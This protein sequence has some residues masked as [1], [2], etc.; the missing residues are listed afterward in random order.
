MLFFIT[1]F[2][3]FGLLVFVS[4]MFGKEGIYAWIGMAVVVANVFVCKSVDL[5]G[6][7][8]TLGNVLFGTV[9]LATDI[10]T[11]LYG[12]K[13]AKKAVWIGV[14]ME[15]ISIILIQLA[16]LFI[17]NSLDLVQDSMKIIFGLF[18]RVAIASCSMFVLSNQLDV[19]LFEKIR[20]KTNGKYLFLRNNVATIIS[21]CIENYLFYIIAFFGIYS[22][23]DLFSMTVVCC[24]IE[25]L[26]ALLDT[27]F[28][29]LAVRGNKN[30]KRN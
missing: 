12:V 25:I 17:P 14:S 6:L 16:L 28:L 27:P 19:Y 30:A 10:L 7:S 1:A 29:Y 23:Q 3:T 21:Q 26:V 8:A 4:R 22:M 5:F 2:V 20:E 15:I 24:G 18:P 13:S 11:E 9:F